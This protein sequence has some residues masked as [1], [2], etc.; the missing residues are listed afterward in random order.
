MKEVFP[1]IQPKVLEIASELRKLILR[2]F[3]AAVVTFDEE[4][5]GFGFGSGYKDLV[6]VISPH[7]EH[8]N[9]GI[10]N[11]ASLHDPRGLMQGTGKLHRHVKLQR[12][13]LLQDPH[14]EEL[15][16]VALQAAQKRIQKGA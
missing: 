13:E 8:V 6:F 10:V 9:L 1:S 5:M 12:V 16:R 11:G 4:N 15:M 7:R 14:L 2:I 3:P